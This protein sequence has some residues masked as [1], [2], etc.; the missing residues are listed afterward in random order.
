MITNFAQ[1]KSWWKVAK[2]S[3]KYFFISW[4]GM[5]LSYIFNIIS[6]IF[7]AYA[8]TAITEGNYQMAMIYLVIEF[9][10]V[11][12][13]YLSKHL[14]Y[15]IFHKLIASSYVPINEKL[16]DKVL[17]AKVSSLKK[18]PKESILNM[19]HV[20]A[21][22]VANLSDSLAVAL[23]RF[24]RV[25]ITI[26]TIFCI[27]WYAGLIVLGVDILN[28]L[29]LSR[30]HNRRLKYLKEIN[31]N[32]DARCKKM[33]ELADGRILAREMEMASVIKQ[34]YLDDT[35]KFIKFEH[36]KTLNQS[37][38]GNFFSIVYYF[39]ILVITLLMVM[40]VANE[41]MTL[42]LYLIITPYIASGITVASDAFGVLSE[43]RIASV[44]AA[45]IKKVLDFKDFD[46]A[47]FGNEDIFKIKGTIDFENVNYSG[48]GS[49]T[50]LKDVSFNIQP[51][52]V[53]LITG[54]RGGGK[55]AV[56]NLLR[57][58]VKPQSG[59][60]KIDGVDI[61][62]YSRKA[63]HDNF[64][65][66]NTKP[67]FFSGSVMKNLRM[68]NKNR[69]KIYQVCLELGITNYV[70]NLPKKFS[71][72]ANSLPSNIQYMLGVARALLSECEIVAL[73]EAPTS[74]NDK[75]WLQLK[76]V[77]NYYSQNKMRTFLVFSSSRMFDDV[78]TKM[79]AIDH[80]QVSSVKTKTPTFEE[81]ED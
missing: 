22:R 20:D 42:T 12:L 26:I 39:A 34:D 64:T 55:R 21:Y 13:V 46:Y 33:S 27:N 60:I 72:E 25:F 19:L 2:P 66:V 30:L 6:P 11:A 45:R 77:L 58:E 8:I 36:K 70:S 16:V 9:L 41:H 74:F 79:I 24:L 68:V 61:N 32:V 52:E 38:V 53:A 7:A 76:S 78:A 75:E 28:F 57:H 69:A 67:Y 43:I 63:H 80:G 81:D 5:A 73:Y 50:G 44:S 29:L 31:S 48:S 49:S 37:Y 71:T 59:S 56:F 17:H 14:N 35:Q 51:Y 10:V 65:Y 54:A 40:L 1:L 62:E 15:Y 18:V 23:A 47:E 3:K 4:L